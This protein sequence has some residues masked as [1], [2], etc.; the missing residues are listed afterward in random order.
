MN[1]LMFFQ[2]KPAY[3]DLQDKIY[4]H[5]DYKKYVRLYAEHI[6]IDTVKL[7]KGLPGA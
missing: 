1:I 4:K 6:Y 3:I 5:N 2:L 7:S